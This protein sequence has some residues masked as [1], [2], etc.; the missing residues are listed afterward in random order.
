MLA[1][2][3]A[4]MRAT[5]EAHMF[6]ECVIRRRSATKNKLNETIDSFSDDATATKCGL[7]MRS[8]S[9]RYGKQQIV[10][11]YDATLR[12]PIATAL[13]TQ[14]RIKITKRFGEALTSAIEYYIV[15]PVQRGPSGIR[16]LLKRYEV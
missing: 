4:R 10:L 9:E 7:D 3:L 1:S 15:G 5:Q 11:I 12:L 6:D 16:L 13:T 14:D 8:G 2:D